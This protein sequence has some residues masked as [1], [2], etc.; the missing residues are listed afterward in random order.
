[1]MMKI[2]RGAAILGA[3]VLA[4][5][6]VQTDGMAVPVLTVGGVLIAGLGVAV[7]GFG[8]AMWDSLGAYVAAESLTD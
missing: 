5:A 1:M 8:R 7:Y 6:A 2:A 4:I 3:V